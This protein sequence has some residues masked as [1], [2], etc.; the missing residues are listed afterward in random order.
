MRTNKLGCKNRV[1]AEKNRLF[2]RTFKL[3]ELQVFVG[4]KKARYTTKIAIA[5][6]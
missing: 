5:W 2:G 3:H 6:D 1:C 4:Q